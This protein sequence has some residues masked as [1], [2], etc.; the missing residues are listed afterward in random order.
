LLPPLGFEEALTVT[1]IHSVAGLLAPGVGLL[2]GRPFRAPH[3]T[4]S[5]IA[6][7]GGGAVPRPGELSLA[8]AGVLFLDE[9]PEF[10]RRVLETLRQ[11]LEQGVVH[12]ARANQSATFPAEVMLV[13]AMNPCPCGY[14]GSGQ[15][16]CRCA[17][18]AAER[19]RHK[20]SGPLLERFDLTLEI[21]PV[22]FGELQAR[23]PG[24]SSATVRARVLAAR[25]RQMARQGTTN[26]RVD[27]ALGRRVCEPSGAA[28]WALL[29]QAA[30]R[31]GWSARSVTRTLRVARTIA[32]LDAAEH[33]E[34]RHLAE[35]LQFR[36]RDA[37]RVPQGRALGS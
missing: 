25:A 29:A 34:A 35:A 3:H 13:A 24:E 2:G 7:V 18:G 12:I 30:D 9:L 14:A 36:R 27:G 20:I 31:F 16:P 26:A 11:P 5:D 33:V 23:A 15:V 37:A 28:C 10:S 32:D 17:P 6:L 1:T 21:P 22:R 8:H 4:A 19:Y